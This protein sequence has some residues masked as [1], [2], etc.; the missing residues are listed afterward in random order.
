[1]ILPKD[2]EEAIVLQLFLV[3]SLDRTTGLPT[4]VNENTRRRY[5]LWSDISMSFV[6]VKHVAD[7]STSRPSKGVFFMVDDSYQ[8]RLP[9]CPFSVQDSL[10]PLYQ[11]KMK[12]NFKDLYNQL[13]KYRDDD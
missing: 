13:S 12:F 2:P 3:N 5:A 6:G 9:R 4:H 11:I 8:V 10:A 1:M 7:D